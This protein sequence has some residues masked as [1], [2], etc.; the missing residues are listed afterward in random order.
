MG[1]SSRHPRYTVALVVFFFVS[2]LILAN[3]PPSRDFR[4][5]L[6]PPSYHNRLPTHSVEDQI[7]L[8]ETHYKFSLAERQKL[9]HK[10]GPSPSQIESFPSHG[11]YYT[12]CKRH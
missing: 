8:S 4:H 2:V 11:E 10:Y 3:L 9:I 1:F 7:Q 12:L 6:Y 5:R